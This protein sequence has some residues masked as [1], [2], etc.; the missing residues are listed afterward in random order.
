ME[1]RPWALVDPDCNFEM[2]GHHVS[3]APFVLLSWA[4]QMCW[5]DSLTA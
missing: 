4:L 3:R 2:F 5:G 1:S